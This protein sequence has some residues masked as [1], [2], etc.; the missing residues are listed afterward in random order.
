MKF[1]LFKSCSPKVE[2]V[3]KCDFE[4]CNKKFLIFNELCL[5]RE[6]HVVKSY[7]CDKENCTYN[8]PSWSTLL[9]H[10]KWS[11]GEGMLEEEYQNLDNEEFDNEI[12]FPI[13]TK[14]DFKDC[15]YK[16]LFPESLQIHKNLEHR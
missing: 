6:S 7:M 11:H 13:W 2:Q 10:K 12:L 5:H 15:R 9:L 14:C 3:Y 8:C 16:C 1:T 4:N